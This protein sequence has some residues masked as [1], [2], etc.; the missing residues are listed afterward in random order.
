MPGASLSSTTARKPP[1]PDRHCDLRRSPSGC[2]FLPVL[3][4][5]P[6]VAGRESNPPQLSRRFCS[7]RPTC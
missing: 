6:N 4:P 1:G 2:P 7:S 3:I 5:G